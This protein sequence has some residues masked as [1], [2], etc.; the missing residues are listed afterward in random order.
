VYTKSARLSCRF[1]TQR[2]TDAILA[3]GR[4]RDRSVLDMGSGDDVFTI[5]FWDRAQPKSMVGLDPAG[6][7][8]AVANTNK[9]NRRVQFLIGDAHQLPFPDNSFDLA[10][11]QGILHHDDN[12]PN[13]IRE[14]F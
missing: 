4:L 3:T 14:A 13:I 9:A 11:L 6:H 10:L 1:A 12:P 7:A 8:I 2:L 5:R